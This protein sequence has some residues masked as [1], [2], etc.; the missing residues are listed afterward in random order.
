MTTALKTILIADDSV[1]DVFIL[2]RAIQKAGINVSI[3]KAGD[4]QEAVDYLSGK[5]AFENRSAHP[6]PHLLLL[7]LKMPKMDG[8][9]VLCWLQRQPTLKRLPVTVLTSS[10]QDED[11]DK[12]YDLGANSY[13]VKPVSI[14]GYAGV[15]EELRDYWLKLNRPPSVVL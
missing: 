15:V 7:D 14:D 5:G 9:D 8:F 1:E 4:G 3:I 6:L 12:A 11:V 13:V 10:N 2:E